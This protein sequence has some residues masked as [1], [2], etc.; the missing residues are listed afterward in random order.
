VERKELFCGVC[1][2][3]DTAVGSFS[4]SSVDEACCH[5][6][7]YSWWRWNWGKRLGRR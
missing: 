1:V 7:T 4:N 6:T 5:L 2:H 3:V